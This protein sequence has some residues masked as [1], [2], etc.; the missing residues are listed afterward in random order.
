M[1]SLS[2]QNKSLKQL[3]FLTA[4]FYLPLNS[5]SY[6]CIKNEGRNLKMKTAEKNA[7]IIMKDAKRMERNLKSRITIP[8]ILHSIWKIWC[9]LCRLFD[10]AMTVGIILMVYLYLT[11]PE[12]A[13]QILKS[14][15]IWTDRIVNMVK[16]LPLWV[17]L[18]LQPGIHV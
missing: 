4:V 12:T 17:Q 13:I 8:N 5:S 10:A 2:E 16:M 14:L 7:T 3:S 1:L 11:Q 6:K 15:P 18:C 9:F